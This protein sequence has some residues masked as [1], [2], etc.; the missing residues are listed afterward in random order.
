MS[1]I[2]KKQWILKWKLRARTREYKK[3][4]AKSRKIISEAMKKGKMAVSWSTGKDS[5]AMCHLIKR[6]Y[7]ETEILIQ[8]DDCDWPEKKRYADRITSSF[9]WKPHVVIPDFSVWN[10]ICKG[11]LG[12]EDFCSTSNK[13]TQ[14]GFLDLLLKKQKELGCVGSF[15]GLRAQESKARK[16]NFHKRGALYIKKNNTWV[17]CPLSEWKTDDV[18]AYLIENN[19]EINPCYFNN[20]IIS[21]EEIRLSWAIPMPNQYFYAD[22]EHIRRYYP[23]QYQRIK[24]KTGIL[25]V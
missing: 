1:E 3:N 6:M 19:I 12:I 5:T 9:Q 10:R 20:Q 18:F 4:I 17:C 24:Q 15:L 23:K 7:P 13:L 22:M 11:T 16:M 8:F 14:E 21:P 25:N 2:R